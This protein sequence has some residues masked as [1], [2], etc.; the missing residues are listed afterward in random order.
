MMLSGKVKLWASL[1]VVAG[2]LVYALAGPLVQVA[3]GHIIVSVGAFIML[4][5]FIG[6]IAGEI[7]GSSI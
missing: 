5:G 2:L 7:K 3:N 4:A 6:I 1:L